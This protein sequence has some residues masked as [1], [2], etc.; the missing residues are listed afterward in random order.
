MDNLN[1]KKIP[2]RLK[3]IEET[4]ALMKDLDEKEMSGFIL[5]GTN[6]GKKNKFHLTLKSMSPLAAFGALEQ[7]KHMYFSRTTKQK[8]GE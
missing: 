6:D 3:N 1:P 2:N 5:I 8:S 7:Y 4:I